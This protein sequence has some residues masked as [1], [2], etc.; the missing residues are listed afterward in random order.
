MCDKGCCETEKCCNEKRVSVAGKKGDPGPRGPAGISQANYL[1]VQSSSAL[2]PV[3]TTIPTVVP[4]MFINVTP[5][6]YVAEMDGTAHILNSGS[7][8][9]S[10]I[11]YG[12]FKDGIIIPSSSRITDVIHITN[13]AVENYCY[14][15]LSSKTIKFTV[16]TAG[17]IDVRAFATYSGLDT[18]PSQF[19][20]GVLRAI[21][22]T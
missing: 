17:V 4:G 1:A 19:L 18:R 16:T 6:V 3:P 21:K 20:G 22:L 11:N 9:R 8:D 10:T 15:S 13:G 5:G 12:I 14:T 7:G 2:S